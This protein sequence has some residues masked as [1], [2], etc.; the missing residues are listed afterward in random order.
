GSFIELD[1]SGNIF[2][3]GYYRLTVDFDPGPGTSNITAVGT[4]NDVFFAKFDAAGN[5]L[6]ARSIG[7]TSNDIPGGISI[8]PTGNVIVVGGFNGTV[9]FD[10]GS[11]T[12]NLTAEGRD[13][14][15]EKYDVNGNYTWAKRI[16]STGTETAY[17]IT[18]DGS[19]GFYVS[20]E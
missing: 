10:P 2:V 11:G 14:F 15:L 13:I 5:F 16:G 19:G 12:E 6:W 9:D 17:A 20:G 4:L 18:G 8:D 7:S 3:S 1:G